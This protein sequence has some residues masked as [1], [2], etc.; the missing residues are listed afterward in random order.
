MLKQI[1]DLLG[2]LLG[3]I[4]KLIDYLKLSKM[5]KRVKEDKKAVAKD[6]KHI[7]E[8]D[9]EIDRIIEDDKIDDIN[10]QLGWKE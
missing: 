10:D 5:E 8:K 7:E 2:S 9:L 1:L 3:A 6:K 4:P